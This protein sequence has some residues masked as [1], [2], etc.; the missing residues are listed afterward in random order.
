MKWLIG[1]CASA[2]VVAC[3]IDPG[4]AVSERSADEVTEANPTSEL[5]PALEVSA[6]DSPEWIREVAR[7]ASAAACHGTTTCTGGT[8][9]ADAFIVECGSPECTKNNCGIGG[10]PNRV[11][12][13]QPEESVQA[14]FVPGKPEPCY[15]YHPVRARP[16]NTCCF[17]D[18]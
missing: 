8:P 7:L 15:Q 18:Q 9:Y 10:P 12:K 4:N 1:L 2:C 14:F 11:S 16:L 17:I 3:A 6:T 5:A 13:V